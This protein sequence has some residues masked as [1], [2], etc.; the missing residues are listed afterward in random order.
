[1]DIDPR[2]VASLHA[3]IYSGTCIACMS[4]LKLYLDF[5][6]LITLVYLWFNLSNL[7]IFAGGLRKWAPALVMLNHAIFSVQFMEK[8]YTIF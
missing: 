6:L 3:L 2:G 4:Q 8:C 1:M 7:Q 5:D